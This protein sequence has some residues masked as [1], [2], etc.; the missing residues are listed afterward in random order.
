[1]RHLFF[2]FSNYFLAA[3]RCSFLVGT[4]LIQ[5]TPDDQKP[6]IMNALQQAGSG[7]FVSL[8]H[9]LKAC[10]GLLDVTTRSL[11]SL[12]SSRYGTDSS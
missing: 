8:R 4:S 5:L 10:H 7:S 2:F 1:M 9:T 6:A 11:F 12:L 3:N